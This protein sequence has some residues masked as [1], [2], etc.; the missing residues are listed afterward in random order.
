MDREK[1]LVAGDPVYIQ[2]LDAESTTD[3]Y[4]STRAPVSVPVTH[5]NHQILCAFLLFFIL[6]LAFFYFI[7]SLLAFE[8]V[9]VYAFSTFGFS[10]Y[11]DIILFFLFAIAT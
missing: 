8:Y 5:P 3:S 6:F 2:Q 11:N 9:C 1:K 4:M 7:I 10:K